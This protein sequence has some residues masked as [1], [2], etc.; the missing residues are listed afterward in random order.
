MADVLS[1]PGARFSRQR[2]ACVGTAADSCLD[3]FLCAEFAAW[4]PI[5]IRSRHRTDA[6]DYCG[7]GNS[8][9]DSDTWRLSANRNRPPR[10]W[11]LVRSNGGARM[12]LVRRIPLITAVLFRDRVCQFLSMVDQTAR[13]FEKIVARAGQHRQL[14]ALRRRDHFHHLFSH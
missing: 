3:N 4:P 1:V 9:V 14:P 11:P 6:G 5:Q 7:L 8:R 2:T 13:A 12:E 10:H